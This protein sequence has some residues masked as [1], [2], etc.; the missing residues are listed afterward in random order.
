MLT[1]MAAP[2]NRQLSIWHLILSYAAQWT[3]LLDLPPLR[4]A[5][6]VKD[7]STYE[8]AKFLAISKLIE[9]YGTR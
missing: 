6:R 7:M 8:L 9:T 4:D 2:Q 5:L 1:M 3:L